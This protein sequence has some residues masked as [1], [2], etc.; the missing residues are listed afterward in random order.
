MIWIC[1]LSWILN[2]HPVFPMYLSGHLLHFNWY[3]PL[4]FY[5]SVVPFLGFKSFHVVLVVV[6]AIRMVVFLNNFFI[7]VLGP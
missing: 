7:V 5:V 6:N 1:F 2:V 3:T 4:W